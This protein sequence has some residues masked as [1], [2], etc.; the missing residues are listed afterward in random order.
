MLRLGSLAAEL[1]PKWR[2]AGAVAPFKCV[3]VLLVLADAF[4]WSEMQLCLSSTTVLPCTHILQVLAPTAGSAQATRKMRKKKT[5]A[6]AGG[7][8]FSSITCGIDHTCA[9]DGEG[10]AWCWGEWHS[11]H[12][13]AWFV[14]LTL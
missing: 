3:C 5:V 2:L 6:V 10:Q 11:V 1:A 9:L 8:T 4:D 14:C 7:H 12:C 13:C